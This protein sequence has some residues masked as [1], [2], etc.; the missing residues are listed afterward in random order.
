MMLYIFV[1]GMTKHFPPGV[2]GGGGGG[3]GCSGG[4]RIFYNVQDFS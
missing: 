2:G 1:K 3:G 4:G